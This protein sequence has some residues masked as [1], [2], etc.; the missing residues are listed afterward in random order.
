MFT[1]DKVTEFFFMA[2]DFHKLFSVHCTNIISM[3]PK[4]TGKRTYHRAECLSI[5]EIMT[6]MVL[7]HNSGYRC[8]KHFYLNEVYVNL[9]ANLP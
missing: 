9:W 3:Y 2:D 5:L 4:N 1:E 8:L 7:F 6:I